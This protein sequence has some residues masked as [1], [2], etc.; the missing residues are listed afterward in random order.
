MSVIKPRCG[1]VTHS[2]TRDIYGNR[3]EIKT[4]CNT[5]LRQKTLITSVTDLR[6][7]FSNKG[8]SFKDSPLWMTTWT[9]FT[10]SR[11]YHEIWLF[12]FWFVSVLR[13]TVP[14]WGPSPGE[15]KLLLGL[16][17]LFRLRS[18]L[19]S[20]LFFWM[21]RSRE[22]NWFFSSLSNSRSSRRASSWTSVSDSSFVV[23]SYSVSRSFKAP[24][25]MDFISDKTD[26]RRLN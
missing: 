5:E 18:M 12:Y 7:F 20:R 4:S 14:A 13:L 25:G 8:H 22:I 17:F 10:G 15:F 26:G 19:F 21:V 24:R 11:N 23:L 16:F 3:T 9:F 6:V 2:Q 1:N